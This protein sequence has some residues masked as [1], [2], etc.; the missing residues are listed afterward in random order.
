MHFGGAIQGAGVGV[1]AGTVY[2]L[3]REGMFQDVILVKSFAP[4]RDPT[5]PS[6]GVSFGSAEAKMNVRHESTQP[7]SEFGGGDA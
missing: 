6:S 2:E 4:T 3:L 7:R 5:H 1:V